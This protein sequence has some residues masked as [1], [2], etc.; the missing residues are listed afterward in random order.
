MVDHL[1]DIEFHHQ[2]KWKQ[3]SRAK[4]HVIENNLDTKL[5]VKDEGNDLNSK[6]NNVEMC[7]IEDNYK[8]SKEQNLN[9]F[10]LR[11]E[12]VAFD[13]YHPIISKTKGTRSTPYYST[14]KTTFIKL[15][16]YNYSSNK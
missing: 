11:G 13:H 12:I 9:H 8:S 3:V 1:K 16:Y 4:V 5:D 7:M 10:V 15:F 2:K 14:K 6:Q